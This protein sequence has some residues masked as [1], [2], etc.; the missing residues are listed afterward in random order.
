MIAIFIFSFLTLAVLISGVVIMATGSKLN[1]KFSNRLMTLR[2]VFQAI[3]IALLALF[4]YL[5][6]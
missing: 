2:V 4:Y 1:A 6:K 5:N 3:V